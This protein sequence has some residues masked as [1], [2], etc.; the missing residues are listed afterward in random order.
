M[1]RAM[2][3]RPKALDDPAAQMLRD[4]EKGEAL[5]TSKEESPF[6]NY[7]P[8]VRALADE[9]NDK[10]KC[11]YLKLEVLGDDGKIRRVPLPKWKSVW[12]KGQTYYYY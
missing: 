11:G 2:T 12:H 5:F 3:N 6:W 10:V 9:Y 7:R 8:S 1:R 4:P